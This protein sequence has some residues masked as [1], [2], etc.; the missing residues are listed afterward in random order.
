M[1][2]VSFTFVAKFKTYIPPLMMMRTMVYLRD[3]CGRRG[4]R[5]TTAVPD[6]DAAVVGSA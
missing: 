1:H 6:I 4:Q 5:R 3:G 2:M